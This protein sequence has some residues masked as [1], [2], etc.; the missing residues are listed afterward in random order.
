MYTEISRPDDTSDDDEDT[1]NLDADTDKMDPAAC[2]RFEGRQALDIGAH[3]SNPWAKRLKHHSRQTYGVAFLH[4]VFDSRIIRSDRSTQ[5]RFRKSYLQAKMTARIDVHQATPSAGSISSDKQLMA[6]GTWQTRRNSRI[7][8]L[9]FGGFLQ[10]VGWLNTAQPGFPAISSPVSPW[11]PTRFRFPWPMRGLRACRRRSASMAICSAVS[12]TPCSGSSR[13]LAIGP[14]SAISL[15]IAGT[16]GAM[17]EGDVQRYAQIASLA[18]FTVAALSLIAWLLRLS[19]LVKLIS[20]SILVG[21]KAGAG[22]TIAMTQLPS[23]FGVKGGG[24]NFF[25][26]AFTARRAARPDAIPRSRRRGYRDPA[27]G[28]W[29]PAASGKTGRARGC[30]AVDRRRDAVGA[31]GAWGADD[32]RNSGRL[33][34]PGRPGAEVARRRGDRSV[35]RGLPAAGLYRGRI[36]GPR[37]RCE[38]RIRAGS[39][40]GASGHRCGQS[41]SGDGAGLSGR[42]RPLA[43][44]GERQGR[45]THAAGAGFCLDHAGA[46]PAVSDRLA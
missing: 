46:L 12:V 19:V 36:C 43:I 21:F 45:R 44:G 38:A 29:R 39:Q 3:L 32:G 22:L 34:H 42:R 16:V 2:A 25:E 10:P 14:T 4:H 31:A 33:A 20:D 5:P 8:Q 24:H 6:C 28:T 17:A 35:G 9:G 15:M 7:R 30:R 18:A 11:R 37:L 27:A 1:E 26:R 41:R 13:Q 40:A 23:L